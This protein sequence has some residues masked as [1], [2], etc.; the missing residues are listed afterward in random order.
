MNID[1]TKE[2]KEKYNDME[3]EDIIKDIETRTTAPR[4]DLVNCAVWIMGKCK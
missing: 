1:L 2:Q 4:Y 3:I